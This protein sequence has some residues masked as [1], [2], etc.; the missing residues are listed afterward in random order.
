MKPI[1]DKVVGV[2]NDVG[3]FLDTLDSEKCKF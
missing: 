3:I 1:L 2:E